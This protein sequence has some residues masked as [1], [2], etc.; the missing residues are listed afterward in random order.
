MK[1][2]YFKLAPS[3]L[4]LK[5]PTIIN[6]VVEGE[7]STLIKPTS[8]PYQ[9]GKLTGI[10]TNGYQ[11]NSIDPTS[12]SL[13]T[14]KKFFYSVFDHNYGFSGGPVAKNKNSQKDCSGI[15]FMKLSSTNNTCSGFTGNTLL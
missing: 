4:K 8:Y 5:F 11:I 15:L 10:A 12:F 3:F 2:V 7:T 13:L 14:G 9:P 1:S 6:Y